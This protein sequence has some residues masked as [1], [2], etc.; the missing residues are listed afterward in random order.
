MGLPTRDLQYPIV[1]SNH[2]RDLAS[3]VAF[4]VADVDVAEPDE[5]SLITYVSSLYD[6][7]PEVPPLAPYLADDVSDR[8]RHCEVVL[9]QCQVCVVV[10]ALQERERKCAEYSELARRWLS[11]VREATHDMQTRDFPHTLIEM[12]VST[13]CRTFHFVSLINLSR[14]FHYFQTIL[15]D[16]NRFRSD[17]LPARTAERQRLAVMFEELESLRSLFE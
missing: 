6:V 16:H 9:L 4:F 14:V 7:F 8:P 17:Q 12:K 15:T 1:H 2:T 13:S 11:W 10:V 3:R 5:R